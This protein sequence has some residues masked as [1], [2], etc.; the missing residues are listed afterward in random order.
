MSAQRRQHTAEFK[1]EAV[2]LITE[3]GV[4]VAR[5]ARDLG[6]S[7]SLL[8]KWKK[9]IE[10]AKGTELRVFP[11]H[12]NPINEELVRLQRENKIL[13]EERD[14]LKKC[15]CACW[16]TTTHENGLRFALCW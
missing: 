10:E 13:R 3:G 16:H 6:V 4:S 5:A 8:G 7:R 9:Q 2:R 11:G 15:P 1:Q 12:G 14:I